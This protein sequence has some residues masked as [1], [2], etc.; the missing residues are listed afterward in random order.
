MIAVI[1]FGWLFSAMALGVPVS[2]SL[3]GDLASS[4]VDVLSLNLC[5]EDAISKG[6]SWPSNPGMLVRNLFGVNAECVRLG[7]GG[8]VPGDSLTDS[9]ATVVFRHAVSGGPSS[10]RWLEASLN[11][12]SD[13]TWRVQAVDLYENVKVRAAEMHLE[14]AR[15]LNYSVSGFD[16]GSSGPLD[17]LEFLQ[18]RPGYW[19]A[20]SFPQNWVQEIDLSAL[21]EEIDSVTPC[22]NVMHMAS[23]YIDTATSTVGNEAAYLVESFRSGKYPP[24]LNST[25]PY[26][27]VE[28]I[29]EWWRL[30]NGT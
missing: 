5:I 3:S 4:E 26:V 2:T 21:M 1:L 20:G 8:E 29:K 22:A 19:V 7:D 24:R 9:S 11:V 15:R 30:R 18:L 10:N 13:G 12:V 28:G 17:L 16:P 27:D 6:E 25:R 14:R 23:S